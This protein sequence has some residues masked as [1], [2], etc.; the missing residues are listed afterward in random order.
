M[1][2]FLEKLFLVFFLNA[3]RT[4]P[5]QFLNFPQLG[6]FFLKRKE[7]KKLNQNKK[8]TKAS[9]IWIFYISCSIISYLLKFTKLI[10]VI[11]KKTYKV[12]KK[13]NRSN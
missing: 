5:P 9:K 12:E 6:S 2:N 3:K 13:K 4:K 8:T 1:N 7:G 11:N 10:F